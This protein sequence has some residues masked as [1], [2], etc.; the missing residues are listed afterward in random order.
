MNKLLCIYHANCVDGFAAAWVIHNLLGSDKVEF[1]PGVYGE[2]PPNVM[3]RN[4]LLVDFSYKRQVLEA[5]GAVANLVFVVDH[6]KTAAEDLAGLRKLDQDFLDPI[7]PGLAA[8]FD[9]ERS[10]AGLTWDFFHLNDEKPPPALINSIEDRDLW[11]FKLP[12]TRE[13]NAALTSYP[14]DFKVW[15]DLMRQPIGE[16]VG[17]GEALLRK[18]DK[19]VAELIA[20]TRRELTIGGHRVPVANLPPIYASDAGNLMAVGQPFAAT[21]YDTATHR[22]FSLRSKPEGLDVSEIAKLYGGGGHRNAAGFRIK[23]ALNAGDVG[24]SLD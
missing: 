12:W 20:L 1:H 18:H 23:S 4:V 2:P 21:Y 7:E 6:H 15:D 3:G 10:G 16:L 17:E 13:I 5:M 9:M 14:F 24:H 19:D 11:R 22:V 8:L